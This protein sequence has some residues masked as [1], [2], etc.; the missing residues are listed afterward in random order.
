MIQPDQIPEG[1]RFKGYQ[2]R[3]I[4]DIIFQTHI[5]CYRLEKYI[6]SWINQAKPI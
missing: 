2:D 5:T 4:Q 3:I 6:E 1:S